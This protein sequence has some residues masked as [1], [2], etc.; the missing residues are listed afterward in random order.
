MHAVSH[1]SSCE[2]AEHEYNECSVAV[3]PFIRIY[4][5]TEDRPEVAP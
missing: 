3:P 2:L 1:F 4:W 5:Q